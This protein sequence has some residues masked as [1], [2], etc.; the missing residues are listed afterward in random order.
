MLVAVVD[1]LSTDKTR[2][3]LENKLK[4]K[5]DHLVLNHQ[6]QGKGYSIRKGIEK[7][8]RIFNFIV[9]IS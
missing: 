6:N 8:R 3:I 2:L 5:I 9:L 7:I 4:D 1:D